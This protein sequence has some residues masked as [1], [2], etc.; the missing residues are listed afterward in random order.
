[1][2][3]KTYERSL[4]RELIKLQPYKSRILKIP[5][6]Y[7]ERRRII[8]IMLI[9]AVSPIIVLICLIITLLIIFESR[10]DGVFF[11][12]KLGW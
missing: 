1:M 5:S 10:G 9:I 8:E 12:Q 7:L 3:K 11:R 2:E 4:K 6:V